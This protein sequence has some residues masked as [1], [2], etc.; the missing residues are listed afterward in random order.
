VAQALQKK[1]RQYRHS[2][3]D[4]ARDSSEN[5]IGFFEKVLHH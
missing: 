2:P 3:G 5:E 1:D 4:G